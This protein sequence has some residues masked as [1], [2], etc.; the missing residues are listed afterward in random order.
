MDAVIDIMPQFFLLSLVGAAALY[1]YKQMKREAEKVAER[2][3]RSEAEMRTGAN[4][5]LVRGSD[6][7]YRLKQD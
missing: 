5:T 2:N 1:G 6:G 7:V 3:R 4:G